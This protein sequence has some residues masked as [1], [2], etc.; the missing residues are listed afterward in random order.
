MCGVKL[1]RPV[2]VLV[3]A[4][5]VFAVSV[6]VTVCTGC[7]SSYPTYEDRVKSRDEILSG[8][9]ALEQLIQSEMARFDVEKLSLAV[10]SGNQLVYAHAFGA[11]TDELFQAASISKVVS[12]YCALSLVEQGKLALDTPLVNYIAEPWVPDRQRGDAITLAMVL[13]HTSGLTNDATG[14]NRKITTPPGEVFHYSGAG[15]AYLQDVIEQVTGV[16]FETYVEDS[17]LRPLGLS[18]SVFHISRADGTTSVGAA[19]TLVSTPTELALFFEELLD[20]KHIDAAI[21]DTMLSPAVTIDEHYQWG[22][23]I[24]LQTGGPEDAI[25]HWGNNSPYRSLVIFYRQSRTGVIIMAKGEKADLIFGDIAHQ[26]IGGSQYG[27]ES[28]IPAD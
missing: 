2:F 16:D 4:T 24:G 1:R 9:P 10:V 14:Q 26:A 18:E 7:G 11:P 17:V 22:L 15:F 5:V 20:P 6:L 23:G 19:Y 12:A 8:I 13:S 3:V 21:V 27:L 28:K 25:W